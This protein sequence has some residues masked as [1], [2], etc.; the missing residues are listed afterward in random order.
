M[1]PF[2]R[3][4]LSVAGALSLRLAAALVAALLASTSHID[5]SGALILRG[6]FDAGSTH[7]VYELDFLPSEGEWKAS[8]LTV[9]LKPVGGKQ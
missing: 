6:F 5:K 2:A 7:V 4:S 1:N 3:P 9:R 8:N